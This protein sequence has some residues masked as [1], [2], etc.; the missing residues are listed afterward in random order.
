MG[1]DTVRGVVMALAA[2]LPPGLAVFRHPGRGLR[3]TERLLL[4]VALGPFALAAPALLL[5]WVL[6]LPVDWALWQSEFLWVV[7]ALC[8][9]T[10]YSIHYTKLYD[11]HFGD[12]LKE[13]RRRVSIAFGAVVF[14]STA[15]Y[16]FSRQLSSLLVVPL[17]KASPHRIT[18]YNVCYTR[19]LRSSKE[20]GSTL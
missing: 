4:A 10:S 14:C 18:S 13:L 11:D 17:F 9:I 20:T 3:L 7:A 16:F 1:D 5:G 8:V 19:L 15:A 6:R 2:L 12:H